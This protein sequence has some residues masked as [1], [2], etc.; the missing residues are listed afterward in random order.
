MAGGYVFS[1]VYLIMPILNF[2]K[3]QTCVTM[4]HDNY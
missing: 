2:V 3:N 4:K 1:V